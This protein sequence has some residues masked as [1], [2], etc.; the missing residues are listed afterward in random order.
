M[1]WEAARLKSAYERELMAV[2]MA[3]QK[4]PP[5]LIGRKFVVRTDHISLK[6]LFEQRTVTADHQK[7]LSI[8]LGYDFDILYKPG[9]CNNV[10]DALSCKNTVPTLNT[11]TITSRFD[12]SELWKALDSEPYI[13]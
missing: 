2:V 13:R 9:K 5:Y 7:W 1:F 12:W 10:V 11:L 4:W 3:I 6:Y 8:L